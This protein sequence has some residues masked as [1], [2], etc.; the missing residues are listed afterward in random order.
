MWIR[1]GRRGKSNAE[2][3]CERPLVLLLSPPPLLFPDL[4][5]S[6]P[7]LCVPGG[8]GSRNTATHFLG[9]ASDSVLDPPSLFA[10]TLS[11]FRLP[12]SVSLPPWPL[13]L[14]SLKHPLNLDCSATSW[15]FSCFGRDWQT[16]SKSLMTTICKSSDCECTLGHVRS[17]GWFHSQN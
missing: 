14:R 9:R 13:F 4:R 3:A 5:P 16:I 10:L 11:P 2:L 15:W 17:L 8:R 12:V 1:R 7:L 6:E